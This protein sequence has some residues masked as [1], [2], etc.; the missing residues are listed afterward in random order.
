M[1]KALWSKKAL[2]LPACAAIVVGGVTFAASPAMADP[3]D[4]SITSQSVSGRV[5]TVTGTGTPGENIQLDEDF[6]NTRQEIP[7]SGTWTISY[8]IPG[9]DTTTQ[10]Y[11]FEQLKGLN[12]DGSVTV[13]A[14]PEA[15]DKPFAVTSQSVSGRTLTVSGTG[16]VGNTVN[17]DVGFPVQRTAIKDDGTWTISYEIPGT[18]TDEHTY[19]INEQRANL[20]TVDSV[21]VTA[22]AEV[23]VLPFAVTSQSVSGRTLTVSG[24]GAVGNTVN[25][26]VGYPVRRTPIADDGTWTI[27]YEIPGTD[28]DE[29]TYTINEQRANLSTVDSVTVTARAEAAVADFNFSLTSPTDGDTVDS[30]TVTFTGTGAVGDTVNVLDADGNRAAPQTIVDADGNWSTTGT[31]SDSAAVEQDLSV[32]QVGG[33]QGQGNIEFSITLPAVAA[34]PG[35]GGDEGTTPGDGGDEGTTPGDGGDQGAT[36]G[37]GTGTGTETGAGGAAPTAGRTPAVGALPVV[38][39]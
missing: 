11:T 6:R 22:R 27:S 8:T 39:G 23:A 7:A 33:G 34:A 2:A 24:T 10:T 30:R 29:H 38:S 18:D 19:T 4:L 13:T 5:L 36:P 21:T 37:T 9:T 28:T 25:F 15:T 20:S 31:F 12:Q 32:N 1:N 26:D 16:A 14:A 3:A 17:F 35:D